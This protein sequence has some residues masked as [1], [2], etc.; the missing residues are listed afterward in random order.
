MHELM[1]GDGFQGARRLWD[2]FWIPG[3][4]RMIDD[5]TEHQKP[6]TREVIFASIGSLDTR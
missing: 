4:L 3:F 5:S 2:R 6:V 1:I